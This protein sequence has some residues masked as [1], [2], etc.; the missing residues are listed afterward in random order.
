MTANSRSVSKIFLV[1]IAE[2]GRFEERER[3]CLCLR[4]RER[5]RDR[6]KERDRERVLVTDGETKEQS[7]QSNMALNCLL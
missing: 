4:K 7:S 5:D 6:E 3:V 2:G 1:A